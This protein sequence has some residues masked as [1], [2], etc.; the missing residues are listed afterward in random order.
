M[1]IPKM[2]IDEMIRMLKY[3]P[4]IHEEIELNPNSITSSNGRIPNPDLMN[5]N[6]FNGSNF[7]PTHIDRL[8][9][10][11]NK[12]DPAYMSTTAAASKSSPPKELICQS[13]NRPCGH[14]MLPPNQYY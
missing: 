2:N 3:K 11:L 14:V 5:Y 12:P 13:C 6:T 4:K 8:E 10:Y 1:K 7:I 9:I